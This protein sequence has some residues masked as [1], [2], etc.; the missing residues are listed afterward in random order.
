MRRPKFLG[1]AIIAMASATMVSS[2]IE[3][4]EP[5]GIEKL[6]TAKAEFIAAET[7]YKTAE[8]ARVNAEAALE[9]LNVKL[10]E[11]ELA[12][13][14]YEAAIAEAKSQ[15][16]IEEA[17]MALEDAK[18]EHELH[19]LEANEEVAKAQQSYDLALKE[20]EIAN[21]T[22][23]D[24]EASYFDDYTDAYDAM[25]VA[26]EQ[27]LGYA[28]GSSFVYGTSQMLVKKQEALVEAEE[29]LAKA[30]SQ[31][32]DANDM[33]T[34]YKW[35][36]I[37]AQKAYDQVKTIYDFYSTIE[38]PDSAAIVAKAKEL[39]N[40]EE[41]LEKKIDALYVELAE[42]E[43]VANSKVADFNKAK[44]TYNKERN[45][46]DEDL[47]KYQNESKYY[48]FDVTGD[49]VKEFFANN[50]VNGFTYNGEDKLVSNSAI[51]NEDLNSTLNNYIY[52]YPSILYICNNKII[53]EEELAQYT[54]SIKELNSQL[55]TYKATYDADSAKWAQTLEAYKKAALD[56]KWSDNTKSTL[57]IEV[58]NAINDFNNASE[59]TDAMKQNIA[60]KIA[61][62]YKLRKAFDGYE[63]TS[64]FY[65]IGSDKV[66]Y[67]EFF[68]GQTLTTEELAQMGNFDY[69]YYGDYVVLGDNNRD[70]YNGAYGDFRDASDKFFSEYDRYTMYTDEEIKISSDNDLNNY[71]GTFGKYHYAIRSIENMQNKIDSRKDWMALQAAVQNVLD[72]YE[73]KVTEL[74]NAN[75][76]KYA[77]L[78]PLKEAMLAAEEAKDN[79]KDAVD[80]KEAEINALNIEYDAI[81]NL[82]DEYFPQLVDVGYQNDYL[83]GLKKDL[84]DAEND[85]E[86]A[87]GMLAAFEKGELDEAKSSAVKMAEKAV[88][89]AKEEV[90]E[91]EAANEE[92]KAEY[93]ATKATFDK[94]YA[95]VSAE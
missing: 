82:E 79:A 22:A 95:I 30:I 50:N 40:Q 94:I 16:A 26:K 48:T 57:Y 90:A 88:E 93:E 13:K 27:Y 42:L 77:E 66:T 24:P 20:I 28:S 61:N 92:A 10:K 65:Y 19:M 63:N 62:Y 44:E 80:E 33:A 41:A 74:T 78:N 18:K 59:K 56:Y 23:L 84:E 32:W 7:A 60:T 21:A 15:T 68:D 45:K 89:N 55:S 2:C 39:R 43:N 86:D 76:D 1:A 6:R 64:A 69:D 47:I 75:A 3:T 85:L 34:K 29:E 4:D 46:V 31:D 58:E 54:Q 73:A 81:S 71:M 72:T 67:S 87:K 70:K 83:L 52:Y 11:V 9:E 17:K 36:V 8:I 14:Q 37:G 12:Q 35:D 53:S 5:A 51:A 25:K 91:A 49:I 38:G